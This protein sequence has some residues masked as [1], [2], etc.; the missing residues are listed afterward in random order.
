M[1]KPQ[2]IEALLEAIPGVSQA[3]VLG[4]GRPYLVALLTVVESELANAQARAGNEKLRN[5]LGRGIAE[6]NEQLARH[7]TIKRFALVVD[8]FSLEGGELTPTLKIKRHAVARKYEA[9]I[10]SIYERPRE[11]EDE[12]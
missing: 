2:P 8:G 9:L 1:I 12:A 5:D 4:D 3:V 6:V 7:E 11:S 10:Q